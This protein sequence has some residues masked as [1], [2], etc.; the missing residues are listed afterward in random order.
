METAIIVGLYS[1]QSDFMQ[2]CTVWIII[3]IFYT[4]S[5]RDTLFEGLY[6]KTCIRMNYNSVINRN[7]SVLNGTELNHRCLKV[8]D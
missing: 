5:W 8:Y 4:L 1:A 2:Y 3:N 7:S 6:M